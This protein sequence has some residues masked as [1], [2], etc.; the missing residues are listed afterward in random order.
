MTFFPKYL[1]LFGLSVFCLVTAGCSNSK[2]EGL[3][4]LYPV[5]LK[6]VQEGAPCADASIILVPQD[7]NRW[8]TGGI[9]DANG[10]AVFRTHG[11]YPGVPAGKYKVTASKVESELIGPPPKDSMMAPPQKVKSYYLIDPEYSDSG[12]SPLL[13]EVVA[14]KNNFEPLDLGKK[15]RVLQN[16]GY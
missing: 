7:G 9:T 1:A 10:V 11:Q 2:P 12:K 6:F 16:P 15:V 8:T 3:P 4:D 13:I 14:G 5:T